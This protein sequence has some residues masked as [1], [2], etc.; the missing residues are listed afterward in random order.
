M[1]RVRRVAAVDVPQY[2]IPKPHSWDTHSVF[3]LSEIVCDEGNGK[4]IVNTLNCVF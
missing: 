4:Y 2:V 3:T 1:S